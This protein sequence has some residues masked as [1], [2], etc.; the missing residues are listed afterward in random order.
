VNPVFERP[1]KSLLGLNTK[2]FNG[3]AHGTM[4]VIHAG[5][6]IFHLHD[7][8]T[9]KRIKTIDMNA[10]NLTDEVDK[11]EDEHEEIEV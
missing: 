4:G 11:D 3:L 8:T 2:E 6:G 7:T 9:G 10:N 5:N 1:V